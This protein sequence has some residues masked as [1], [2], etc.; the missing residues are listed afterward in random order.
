MSNIIKEYFFFNSKKKNSIF[1]LFSAV[2][3]MDEIVESY[4]AQDIVVYFV[5]LHDRS[6]DLFRRSVLLDKIGEDRIFQK[7]SHAIEVIENDMLKQR[8]IEIHH[9]Q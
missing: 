5:R 2:Q 1:I 4:H 3:I 6:L 7:V 8:L 9:H